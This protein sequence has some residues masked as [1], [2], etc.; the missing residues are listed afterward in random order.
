MI[1]NESSPQIKMKKSI[2]I[3]EVDNGYTVSMYDG[4]DNTI[5]IAESLDSA[6][7]MMMEMMSVSEKSTKKNKKKREK[8]AM[9]DGGKMKV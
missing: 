3:E 9:T 6:R 4:K 2:H 7:D 5:K 8:Y 1:H